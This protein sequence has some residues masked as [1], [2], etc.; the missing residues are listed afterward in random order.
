[1]ASRAKKKQ[2]VL[3]VES[4]EDVPHIANSLRLVKRANLPRPLELLVLSFVPV[5]ELGAFT[6]LSKDMNELV[7]V[8]FKQLHQFE[9]C[10][11]EDLRDAFELLTARPLE[12]P[13]DHAD[14]ART[15]VS[16][17]RHCR[18][19]RSLKMF[20]GLTHRKWGAVDA[21]IA[22]TIRTNAASLRHVACSTS[23]LVLSALATCTHLTNLRDAGLPD[24]DID[25]EDEDYRDLTKR[26]A[27][28]MWCC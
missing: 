27:G 4:K 1:M 18:Q 5:W 20:S 8:F 14:S 12:D 2:R 22:G 3:A 11:W 21:L 26:C 13:C 25:Y 16:L 10:D 23:L 24:D 15:A 6:T 9:L 7:I 17:L 19:L 28:G